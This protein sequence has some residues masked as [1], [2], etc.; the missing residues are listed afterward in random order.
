MRVRH[1]FKLY[2]LAYST[3][4]ENYQSKR[5]HEIG[6][7]DQKISEISLSIDERGIFNSKIFDSVAVV[8]VIRHSHAQKTDIYRENCGKFS[9][10]LFAL[11]FR[12]WLGTRLNDGDR[13]DWH[14]KYVLSWT[15]FSLQKQQHPMRKNKKIRRAKL[16]I[17]KMEK[18]HRKS[19]IKERENFWRI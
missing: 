9:H 7:R 17:G 12:K 10:V 3:I 5:E 14:S 16:L 13:I 1:P 19:H 18:R 2:H 4:H 15:Q 6:W 11:P 8:D